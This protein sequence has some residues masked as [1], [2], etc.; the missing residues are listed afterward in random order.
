MP[1]LCDAFRLTWSMWG[2][3]VSPLSRVTPRYRAVSTHWISPPRQRGFGT[4]LRGGEN[5]SCHILI[6]IDRNPPLPEPAF[7]GNEIGLKVLDQKL[8]LP[9]VATIILF[10][11]L[12]SLGRAFPSSDNRTN[13]SCF[14][15]VAQYKSR[16][17]SM[18]VRELKYYMRP[19][20]ILQ[21][22]RMRMFLKNGHSFLNIMV[23]IPYFQLA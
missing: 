6:H 17:S 15:N 23:E 11:T 3:Q 22:Q 19:K 8:V 9:D 1:S 16:C 12:S 2:A 5:C 13:H 14:Y 4:R 18:L 10:T 21:F 20:K 7:K